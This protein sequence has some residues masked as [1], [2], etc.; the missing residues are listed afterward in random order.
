[1]PFGCYQHKLGGL[2]WYETEPCDI[3]E[4]RR[5]A[6]KGKQNCHSEQLVSV[7]SDSERTGRQKVSDRILASILQIL[8]SILQILASILQI[9]AS[10][11]Q[12]LASILQIFSKHFADF[13]K[14]FADF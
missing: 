8:A 2:G 12:I 6:P 13:I 7:H 5:A 10:I 9:L 1:M 11:L 3:T 4:E 14:H